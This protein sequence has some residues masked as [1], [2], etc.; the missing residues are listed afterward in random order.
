MTGTRFRSG[1][2][3]EIEL[4]AWRSVGNFADPPLR[5]AKAS[6]NFPAGQSLCLQSPDIGL[7]TARRAAVRDR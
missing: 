7:H 5:D 2:F 1:V 3:E 4:I 6:G